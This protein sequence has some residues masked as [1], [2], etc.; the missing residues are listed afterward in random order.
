MPHII[1]YGDQRGSLTF[2]FRSKHFS[3]IISFLFHSH[4]DVCVLPASIA[5]SICRL[6]S[7]FCPH[8]ASVVMMRS[9][10]EVP[11]SLRSVPKIFLETTWGHNTL[12]ALLLSFAE[13]NPA[14]C[15]VLFIGSSLFS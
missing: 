1:T 9:R 12:S 3:A 5:V 6:S 4:F 8:I 7:P 2:G 14:V 15:V 13:E 11:L 10:I